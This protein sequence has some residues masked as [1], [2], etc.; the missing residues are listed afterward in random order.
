M[1]SNPDIHG[2][3]AAGYGCENV[4]LLLAF[5][6][7]VDARGVDDHDALSGDHSVNE[8]DIVGARVNTSS[9]L[10]LLSCDKV[11]ELFEK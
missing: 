10:L 5:A 1:Q 9:D 7:V 4:S 11:D 6:V 3:K 2:F 8:V